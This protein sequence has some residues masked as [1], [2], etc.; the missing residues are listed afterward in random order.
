MAD[1]KAGNTASL[2][3][4][5]P[6]CAGACDYC[7]FY[8]IPVMPHDSRLDAYPE[9]LLEEAK[10][11]IQEF[12]LIHVPTVY[13]GGGT[14]SLLG[15][16]GMGRLLSGLGKLWNQGIKAPCEI[17]VE[18]NPE[19]AGE[20]FLKT[21]RDKGVTRL[22]LG[23]Q[24]FHGPSRSEVHRVGDGALLQERLRL[25][26]AIFGTDFSGDLI[27]GL[28]LQDERILLQDLKQLLAYEPGHVSLYALTLEPGTPLASQAMLKGTGLPDPDRADALWIAGRDTLEQQ[29][30]GQYE[31]SNFSRPGMEALHNIRY[32]RMEN[33]L[34]LGP[35]ASATIIDNAAGRGRRFT[36]SPD[37]DAYISWSKGLPQGAGEGLLIEDL[38]RLTLIKETFLMGF[39]YRKGPDAGLFRQR[40]GLDMETCIPHTLTRWRNQGLL[41]SDPLTLTKEGLLF[42]DAFLEAAFR[43]L[44]NRQPRLWRAL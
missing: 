12:G 29:G 39:R 32:W 34:G 14:P 38:D 33:W 13:I 20:A 36:V 15:P 24:T 21:C 18:A 40:F 17:T 42:L 11:R 6:F 26:R 43:E 22:S 3:I 28:P 7:D 31:V 41:E 23:I 35:G 19:S 5:V 30:Y 9:A 44:E 25:V 37:V 16:A 4:H 1:P 2:Y 27:T 8:S 10:V